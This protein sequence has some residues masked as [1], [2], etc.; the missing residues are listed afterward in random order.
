MGACDFYKYQPGSDARQAFNEATDH[1]RYMNG[2]G[3]YTGT[4]A[5]KPSFEIIQRTPLPKKEAYE[6][7]EK[8]VE[9]NDKWGPAFAIPVQDEKEPNKTAGWLFFGFASS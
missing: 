2:H 5:E 9:D 7:A 1:A 8:R 6:L 4:I 3:G